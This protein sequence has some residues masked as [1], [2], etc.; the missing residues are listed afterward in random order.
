MEGTGA[1]GWLVPLLGPESLNWV[2]AAWAVVVS[3]TLTSLYMGSRDEDDSLPAPLIATEMSTN[4]HDHLAGS[5]T[6]GVRSTLTE[7]NKTALLAAVLVLLTVPSYITNSLPLPPGDV[8]Q[9]TPLT[10]GCALPTFDEYG[11]HE[12][13]FEHYLAESK[14]LDSTAHFILW[15][16][17]AVRF[18]SEAQKN[19]ALA[20]VREKV[21]HA[22][23]GVAFEETLDDPKD[24]KKRKRT[25][26]AIV[27]NKSTTPHLVYYKQ[28]LVPSKFSLV[29]MVFAS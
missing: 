18:K 17:G 24:S 2:V 10:V 12:L 7:K 28:H 14:K 15:P 16:E 29:A 4:G 11:V 22:F 23:V 6:S 1:Y 19:N 27:S 21:R 26:I 8:S 25:G 20:D 3:Q 9:V 5:E 13:D